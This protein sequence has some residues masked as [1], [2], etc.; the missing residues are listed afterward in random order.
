MIIKLL[1]NLEGKTAI[2]TGGS[3]GLGK[4]MAQALSESGAKVAIISRT[5][6]ELEKT[7]AEI[8]NAGGICRYKAIDILDRTKFQEFV[9]ELYHSNGSIDILINAAGINKRYPFLE[10][11]ESEWD[12]VLNTNL[13]SVYQV[14]QIV[15]PY[16][17]KNDYGK[18]I[19]IASLSSE[20]GLPNMAAYVASKGAISQLTKALAVEFAESGINVNAIGPGYFKTDLTIPL[21]KDK[22]KVAWMKSRI[23]LKRIGEPEDLKGA[24]VFLASNASDYI[25]G[26][27]INV[28]GGWLIS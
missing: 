5:E 3:R 10:F 23:P 26:Q 14:T 1:F 25:T 2:I 19:N 6:S 27:T 28:D 21:L 17:L 22:E 11:P 24:A 8:N 13:K 20:I 4:A 7:A 16:M 15:I 9:D 18:I 12:Q